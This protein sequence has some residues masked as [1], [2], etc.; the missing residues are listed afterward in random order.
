MILARRS[1]VSIALAVSIVALLPREI[2]AQATVEVYPGPG[3][4]T[5]KSNLYKVEVLDGADWIPAYV[6]AFSRESRCHWHFGDHPSVNFVTF[7]TS[8]PVDVR[9][10]KLSGPI[11]HID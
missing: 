11:T 5:Y 1:V 9:V 6:Y 4:N 2:R 3:V 10:T 7:G 8:R